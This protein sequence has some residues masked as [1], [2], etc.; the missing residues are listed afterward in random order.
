MNF[1]KLKK[2]LDMNSMQKGQPLRVNFTKGGNNPVQQIRSTMKGEIMVQLICILIFFS[3][4]FFVEMYPF[5]RSTYFVFMFLTA[6]MTIAYVLK[7]SF[8]L[9]N[10]ANLTLNTKEALMQFI[11]DTK[12]TLEVY[13][14]FIISGSLLLPISF[15]ALYDGVVHRSDGAIFEKWF[16][17]NLSM[18]ELIL[19]ILGYLAIAFFFYITTV[20]WADSLYGKHLKKLENLMEDLKA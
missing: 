17:L 20:K 15:L 14:S 5:A 7:L 3:F 16:T 10:T 19:L 11:Y 1:D 4:P 2:E 12:L 6:L 13:K 18:T 9:K 8:F